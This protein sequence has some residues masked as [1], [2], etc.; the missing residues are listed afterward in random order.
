MKFI[1]FVVFCCLVMPFSGSSQIV[2]IKKVIATAQTDYT[3]TTQQG[4]T[5]I[6]KNASSGLPFIQ[7]VELRLRNDAFWQEYM[8]YSIRV[9]PKGWGE[10]GASRR[11]FTS[12]K[13]LSEQEIQVRFHDALLLRY[14]AILEFL[15][16]QVMNQLYKELI[17]VLEDRIKVLEKSNYSTDFDLNNVIMAEDALTK[18]RDQNIQTDKNMR[19]YLWKIREFLLDTT[20]SGF[21]TSNVVG[22][23]SVSERVKAL[24]LGP[25]TDNIHLNNFRL[26]YSV[27]EGKYLVEKAMDR[28]Y[29]SFASFTYDYGA[30]ID[31]NDRR[32]RSKTYDLNSRYSVELGFSLPFFTSDGR[33]NAR[34]ESDFLGAK[35]AYELAKRELVEKTQRDVRDVE[36]LITHYRYLLARQNEVNA[37]GSLQKYLQMSGI[38]PLMLLSIKEGLLQNRLRIEKV[39]FDILR[40][41]L[42]ILDETGQMSGVPVVNFLS[43]SMEAVAP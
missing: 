16:S 5:N 15:A 7:D 4:K 1:S 37:Q 24:S 42:Q 36:A 20:F 33:D 23:E 25:D 38:N 10:E 14:T 6:L 28:R 12:E 8:R 43:A 26:K 29:I 39:R 19:M 13:K 3:V 2:P 22:V 32:L 41:Y 9:S 40:N 30:F 11:L 35:A 34:R 18:L 21:D 27:S 31:E 17:V